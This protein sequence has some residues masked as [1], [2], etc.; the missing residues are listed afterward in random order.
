MSAPPVRAAGLIIFRVV[1]ERFQYLLLQ[2]S[3]GVH[4]WTPPKGHL[5]PGEDWM[6]AARRETEEEAG[7]PPNSY[8]ILQGDTFPFV[9][10]YP[11]KGKPKRVEYWLAYLKNPDT[12]IKLSHEHQDFRWVDLQK[13]K[14][15][16]GPYPDFQKL[17]ERTEKYLV[18]NFKR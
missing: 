3:N 10:E 9:L 7:L 14:D 15:I 1:A 13:S 5:D 12:P 11:V 4:H 2:A 18:D 16:T 17:M 6:T 8:D